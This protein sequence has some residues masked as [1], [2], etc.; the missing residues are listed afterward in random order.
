[1]DSKTQPGCPAP[2]TRPAPIEAHQRIET[3]DIVRGLALAGILLINIGAM[4]FP[5]GYGDMY[6]GLF[7]GT[8]DRIADWGSSWLVEGKLYTMFSFLFGLGVAIQMERASEKGI[9]LTPWHCRR[10]LVLL[11]IG[12]LHDVLIWQGLILIA[13]SLVGFLILPFFRR[14]TKTLLIWIC[15]LLITPALV[16]TTITALNP[17]RGQEKTTAEI[18]K[19]DLSAAEAAAQKT[20]ASPI[21]GVSSKEA[22]SEG[23]GSG[24]LSARDSAAGDPAEG[25]TADELPARGAGSKE[26]DQLESAADDETTEERFAKEVARYATGSYLEQVRDRA[27]QVPRTLKIVLAMGWYLLGM[28]LLGLLSWRHGVWKNLESSRPMLIRVAGWGLGVG[29]PLSAANVLTRILYEGEPTP[30]V[31]AG[32]MLSRQ[33][34]YVILCLA[35]VA[36]IVLMLR[37]SL[38]RK[39]LQPFAPVGRAALSNYILQSVICTTIFYSHGLGLFGQVGPAVNLLIVALVIALQVA[40]SAWWMERFRFGPAE[41]A[42]RSLSYGRAMKLRKTS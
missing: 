16:S 37:S 21:E 15:A 42:W 26:P 24:K 7:D 39:V 19:K 34:S 28:F 9:R 22:T 10:L 14:K 13:Y 25:P 6:H 8:L 29:L 20:T 36:A 12:L 27:S 11:V 5:R 40:L 2:D 23:S 4:S 38:G 30:L 31:V 35:Y 41:W 18:S 33:L 3:I 17:R 1:M 32:F